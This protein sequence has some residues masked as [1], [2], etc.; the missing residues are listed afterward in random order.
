MDEYL[1][2]KGFEAWVV[3]DVK[4]LPQFRVEFE[5][6]TRETAAW[7]LSEA[8]K[9]RILLYFTRLLIQH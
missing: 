9:V 1:M 5:D 3:M 4:P 8:G 6:S 2:Y 7:I